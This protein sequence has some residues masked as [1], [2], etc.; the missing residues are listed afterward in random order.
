MLPVSCLVEPPEELLVRET[1]QA[2][3]DGLKAEMLE[4]PTCDVQPILTIVNLIDGECQY[5]EQST[6]KRYTL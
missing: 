2:F 3:I 4:N 1:N 6:L 5:S